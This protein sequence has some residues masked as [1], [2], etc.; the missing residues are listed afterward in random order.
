MPVDWLVLPSGIPEG[1]VAYYETDVLERFSRAGFSGIEIHYGKR[2]GN[3][4]S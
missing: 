1:A 2:R 4:E 3:I